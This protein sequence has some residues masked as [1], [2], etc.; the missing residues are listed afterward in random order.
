M[1]FENLLFMATIYKTVHRS[2]SSACF[3]VRNY[4]ADYSR[5]AFPSSLPVVGISL[6]RALRFAESGCTAMVGSL[7]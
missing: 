5:E 6:R 4:A 2:P 1:V 3:A 7:S